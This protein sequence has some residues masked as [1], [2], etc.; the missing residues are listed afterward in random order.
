MRQI[1]RRNPSRNRPRHS[2]LA[3]RVA[4][5]PGFRS[6]VPVSRARAGAIVAIIW[7][8]RIFA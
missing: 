4:A 2:A 3:R 7:L 5:P 1:M 6:R 8:P